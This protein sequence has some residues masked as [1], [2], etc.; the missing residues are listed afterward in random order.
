MS[1]F[2]I[3]IIHQ[4]KNLKEN[5]ILTNDFNQNLKQNTKNNC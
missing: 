3:I 5:K 4:R 1:I 2:I